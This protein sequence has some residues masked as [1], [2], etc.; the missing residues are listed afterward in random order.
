[1]KISY[2]PTNTDDK[3][4]FWLFWDVVAL[5]FAS[6]PVQPDGITF[7]DSVFL[8]VLLST[9]EHS[10]ALFDVLLMDERGN[11]VATYF[12]TKSLMSGAS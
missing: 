3:G 7:L 12:N 10:P 11:R 4:K 2:L 5:V 9:L 6:L 8:D 1:M